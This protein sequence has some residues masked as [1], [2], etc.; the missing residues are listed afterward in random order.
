VALY[1]LLAAKQALHLGIRSSSSSSRAFSDLV[2]R[3]LG[4]DETTGGD[5]SNL[6][7][8]MNSSTGVV[9]AACTA[10]SSVRA[11]QSTGCGED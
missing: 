5:N 7:V 6:K 9:A 10:T 11:V 4:I 1:L 2:T 3:A 8:E